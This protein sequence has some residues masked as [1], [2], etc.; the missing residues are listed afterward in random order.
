MQRLTLAK[1]LRIRESQSSAIAG[2]STSTFS[3]NSSG[4]SQES[5]GRK[6]ESWEMGRKAVRR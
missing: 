1:V 5:G 6:R 3:S 2:T 4:K